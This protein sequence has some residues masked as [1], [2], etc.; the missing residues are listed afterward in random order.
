[1]YANTDTPATAQPIAASSTGAGPQA[2]TPCNAG[3][4]TPIDAPMAVIVTTVHR[5]RIQQTARMVLGGTQTATRTWTRDRP[6]GGSWKSRDMDWHDH[7]D[8]IGIELAEYMH[9]L[10]LPTRVAAMLPR[11]PGDDAAQEVHHG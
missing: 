5:D 2:S 11:L 1:M 9:A 8:R 4:G 10:D 3:G 7:E 6:S